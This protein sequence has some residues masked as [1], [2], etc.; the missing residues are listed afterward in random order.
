MRRSYILGA[1]VV[2]ITL[3]VFASFSEDPLS[4]L[5]MKPIH[6][7]FDLIEKLF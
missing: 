4:R 3:V 7:V 2:A 5:I 1:A 6:A